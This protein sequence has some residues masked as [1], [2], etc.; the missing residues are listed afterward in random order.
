MW[1]FMH[2]EGGNMTE[3][4]RQGEWAPWKFD[5]EANCGLP[6]DAAFALD[7]ARIKGADRDLIERVANAEARAGVAEAE[8]QRLREALEHIEET[9]SESLRT[10]RNI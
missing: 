7:V 9:A 1:E 5:L 3:E 6:A 4:L 10:Y 2:A 8:N